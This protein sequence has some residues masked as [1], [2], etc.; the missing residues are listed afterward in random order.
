MVYYGNKKKGGGNYEPRSN[1]GSMVISAQ[2]RV[3]IRM[4]LLRDEAEN[5]LE[6][7]I[8][9]K[10]LGKIPAMISEKC[11]ASLIKLFINIRPHINNYIKK[12]ELKIKTVKNL[13]KRKDIEENV[14]FTKN[15][16]NILDRSYS[17]I[18]RGNLISEDKI[19]ELIFFLGQFLY[20]LGVTRIEYL[21]R[22]PIA[23]FAES[24]YGETFEDEDDIV[25]E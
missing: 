17:E 11:R 21:D 10:M 12:Q 5:N 1:H 14:N 2:D 23:E 19:Y 22:D 9:Y 13:E 15:N 20:D 3:K 24:A 25:V 4:L 7:Y 16:F 8:G 18:M 6:E